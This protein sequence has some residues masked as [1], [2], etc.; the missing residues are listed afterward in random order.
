MDLFSAIQ[1][2]NVKN[3][4][5]HFNKT[6]VDELASGQA[7]DSIFVVHRATLREYD[8]GH[9]LSLRLGDRTGKINAILWKQA[10]PAFASIR[11]GGLVVV[12]GRVN[13]YKNELQITVD[14]I[15]PVEDASGIDPSAFL[16]E[17][18]Y[19]LED[20]EASF[21]RAIDDIAD[22]DCKGLLKRFREDSTLW[23]RF[24]SAPGAKLW[25]H[26]YLRGL[27]EHTLSVVHLARVIGGHYEGVDIDLLVTG[28]VFHDC[29]KLEEFLFD[30]RI[31]Y[32]TD[33]RLMGHICMGAL[34][35]DRL[36]HQIPNFPVEKR[37]RL[38]HMVLSHHG[39]R[40]KGAPITPMTLEACLLHHLENMDAQ[41][42][43]FQREMN[44]ASDSKSAWTGYI[45]LI[46]RSLY[47]GRHND[48]TSI[49]SD[50]K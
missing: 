28:A 23:P 33:G 2:P 31:D 44:K 35:V 46:E 18:P 10:E 19:S 20:L 39:E 25:H 42:A 14:C 15:G 43:A 41:M 12:Q 7:V 5:S 13:L 24:A 37:R 38:L 49:D 29:G 34:I 32:S 22:P 36:I 30:Y 11:E 3:A 9:F 40:E 6:Y 47:L 17:S 4:S 45:N 16:P 50:M 1:E 8:K 48:D 27:L 26:P 21:D